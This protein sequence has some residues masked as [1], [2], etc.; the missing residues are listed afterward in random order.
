MPVLPISGWIGDNLIK[1]TENMAWWKGMDVIDYN[2]KGDKF[3]IDT[4]LDVLN[5]MVNKPERKPDAAMRLPISGVYKI[6]GVGDVLAGRVE[7]GSVRPGEDVVFIPTHTV[8]N[9]C[10]GKVFT[11]E[12]HHKRVDEAHPGDNVGMNIKGLD[13]INMPRTGDVMIYKKDD[14]LKACQNFN[15][16]VQV[17]DVPG[18]LKPGY[19]PVAFVRCGRSACKMTTSSSRSARR[20]AARS[21]SPPGA[22]VQRGCRGCLRAP[23][24]LRC[25]PLQGVRRPRP[26]R[27]PRRQH[28]RH[29]RQDHQ[30]RVQGGQVNAHRGCG[31]IA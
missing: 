6:K 26:H 1:K 20:P 9:P 27:V 19:S 25:R 4:L 30:G 3:H 5:N 18:Q 11:V 14:S 16:Q 17:L 23:A 31:P 10:T 24:P 15:A 12:M 28:R 13:K 29:A 8:S 22:Q 21:S 2:L 7:Q